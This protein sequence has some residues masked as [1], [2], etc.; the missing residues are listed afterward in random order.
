MQLVGK[1]RCIRK[2]LE[3]RD[4]ESRAEKKPPAFHDGAGG[5]KG[6]AASMPLYKNSIKM[7][8]TGS[9]PDY[10]SLS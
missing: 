1:L 9:K 7:V 5:L 6:V 2:A 10:S 3:K 8:V 4:E